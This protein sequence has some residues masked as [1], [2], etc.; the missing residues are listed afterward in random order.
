MV[1]VLW[2]TSMEEEDELVKKAYELIAKYEME[3]PAVL[4]LES[5]KPLVWVG[6]GLARIALS[7]FMMLFWNEGHAMIDTFEK[8]RNIERLIKMLEGRQKKEEAKKDEEP[9]GGEEAVKE[10]E[11]PKAAK[12]GWRRFF[13]F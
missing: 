13:R 8:R 3:V 4:L 6:G 7:P 10:E 1:M 5:I 9:K 2:D 12:K 11:P